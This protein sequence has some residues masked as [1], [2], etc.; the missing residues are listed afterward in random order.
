[1]AGRRGCA[2]RP[3][4]VL[5]R[6]RARSPARSAP[7]S[8][9]RTIARWPTASSK[10]CAGWRSACGGRAADYDGPDVIAFLTA[11]Y[12]PAQFS[13]VAAS[14][15]TAL[16][17]SGVRRHEYAH[18][19]L[20]PRTRPTP[21]LRAAGAAPR[22][23]HVPVV[24]DRRRAGYALPS[25]HAGAGR[26]AAADGDRGPAAAARG[27]PSGTIMSAGSSRA[28]RSRCARAF[29]AQVTAVHFTDGAIVQKGQLLFTID[30]RP[31][32]AALAEARAGVASA[33]QRPRARPEPISIARQRLV[34][35]DAV[36]KSEVDSLRRPGPRRQRRARR[37]AG[38]GPRA[39]ARHRIHPG[40]RA[41][42]RAR[43]RPPRRCRAI[44]SPRAKARRR[45]LL[46]TINALDPIYFAFDGSEGLFLKSKR[47]RRRAARVAGRRSACRTR[48]TIAGSGRLDF[49]DNGL[50]PQFG[51]DP[52]ARRARA[53]RTCS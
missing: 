19:I 44:W 17:A 12:S 6:H 39:R 9:R 18:Q 2:E 1:M 38:A 49:T 32:A 4:V 28:A 31:F 48:P 23:P 47:D 46:T 45:R 41:D 26:P 34:A 43:V 7:C 53:I 16:L 22:S 5:A 11:G 10:R 40:A 35:D 36:S 13:L 15:D 25:R 14:I 29:R 3:S 30:P 37:G 20:R 24:P 27:R 33:Q 50:D 52:R 42:R 51:H 21:R 8:A